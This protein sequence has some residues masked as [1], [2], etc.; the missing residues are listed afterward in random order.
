[1]DSKEGSPEESDEKEGQ[2]TGEGGL[3]IDLGEGGRVR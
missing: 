1:M 2:G 3:S